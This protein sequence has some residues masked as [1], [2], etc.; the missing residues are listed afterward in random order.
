MK[1]EG[2][3]PNN[4]DAE[5]AVLG[6]LMLDEGGKEA[7]DKMIQIGLRS[8][9]FYHTKHQK[10]YGAIVALHSEGSPV[11]LVTLV[12]KLEADDAQNRRQRTPER[13]QTQLTAN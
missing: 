7:I 6:A 8:S 9:H 13:I 10:V 4:T 3:P 11:T 12:T 1:I 5:R 2:V